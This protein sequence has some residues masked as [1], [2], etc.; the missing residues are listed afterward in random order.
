MI[1]ILKRIENINTK[2]G[3]FLL[4]ITLVI[5]VALALSYIMLFTSYLLYSD[6]IFLASDAF[7]VIITI[8]SLILTSLAIIGAILIVV[9]ID[10]I[11]KQAKSTYEKYRSEIEND[12]N[13][14]HQLKRETIEW[15]LE[16]MMKNQE[17]DK[18][19]RQMNESANKVN[20]IFKELEKHVEISNDRVL[21]LENIV[22]KYDEDKTHP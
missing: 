11:D 6:K 18:K 16:T 17:L 3:K 13:T 12:L 9:K 2:Y 20:L 15:R 1:K 5:T 22:N 4:F 8:M 14:V 7:S 19:L 10:D 21:R